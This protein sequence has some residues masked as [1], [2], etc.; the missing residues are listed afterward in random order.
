[1]PERKPRVTGNHT[2][3]TYRNA[4]N[5]EF[6][7][8]N[9]NGQWAAS[10]RKLDG[11]KCTSDTECSPLEGATFGLLTPNKA[12]SDKVK[13]TLP[14]SF[15][16]QIIKDGETRY[17]PLKVVTTDKDGNADL[18]GLK[19]DSYWVMELSAPAGYTKSDDFRKI[20]KP[21]AGADAPVVTVKNFPNY[22]L[23]DSGGDG[24]RPGYVLAGLLIA[25]ALGGLYWR[26]RSV[27]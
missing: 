24:F 10:I 8:V 15:K 13:A 6:T 3:F 22:E 25:G 26:R 1:M 14:E 17:Y 9:R 18:T 21:E 23:P 2:M 20:S 16:N 19:E 7:A 11:G 5:P 4:E 27:R 12:E